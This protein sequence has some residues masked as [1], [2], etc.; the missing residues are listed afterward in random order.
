MI[1]RGQL[2]SLAGWVVESRRAN[3][4]SVMGATRH[5]HAEHFIVFCVS[6]N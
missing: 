1:V 5:R 4:P 6:S 2:G 3:T